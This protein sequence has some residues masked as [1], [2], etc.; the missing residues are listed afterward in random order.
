MGLLRLNFCPTLVHWPLETAL[1]FQASSFF[2]HCLHLQAHSA[3]MQSTYTESAEDK[4]S[5]ENMHSLSF[6]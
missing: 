1:G 4:L 5:P 2:Q 6:D 3:R